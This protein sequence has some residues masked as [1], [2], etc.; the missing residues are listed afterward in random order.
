MK[1]KIFIFCFGLIIS[2]Y[3]SAQNTPL[4][5]YLSQSGLWGYMDLE[6]NIIVEPNYEFCSIYKH[7]YAAAKKNNQWVILDSIGETKSIL[8]CD[9]I[10]GQFFKFSKYSPLSCYD[11]PVLI[12][13]SNGIQSFIGA[14][15]N[16]IN[17]DYCRTEQEDVDE[18]YY[19]KESLSNKV[20]KK[21]NLSGIQYGFKYRYS[22]I[23]ILYDTIIPWYTKVTTK[24]INNGRSFER[25]LKELV[26]VVKSD[27]KFGMLSQS[28]DTIIPIIHDKFHYE[29]YV[30]EIWFSKNENWK[31]FNTNGNLIFDHNYSINDDLDQDVLI[32]SLDQKKGIINRSGNVVIGLKKSNIYRSGR[33]YIVV[34]QKDSTFLY[35]NKAELIHKF[36]KTTDFSYSPR[37][38]A[39]I[40][41][42]KGKFG[43]TKPDGTIV[44][45]YQYKELKAI[46]YSKNLSFKKK[47]KENGVINTDGKILLQPRYD[48]ILFDFG[49]YYYVRKG[50][51][52]YFVHENGTEFI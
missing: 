32:I 31:L 2:Y 28:G 25:S 21:N 18:D 10:Q 35:S 13:Y 16:N 46:K 48:E 17:H 8:N 23:P 42:R 12:I 43:L 5:P 50:N 30:S 20:I 6:K 34:E 36:L 52:Y 3:S 44:L 7:G 40:N 15:G 14:T 38:T 51:V 26:F 4:F 19:F 24:H 22:D 41:K 33:E 1:M 29:S 39:F 27:G 47:T 11:N 49:N 45:D 37:N 9:S